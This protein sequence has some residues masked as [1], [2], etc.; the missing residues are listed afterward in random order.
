MALVFTNRAA[1]AN[2][3][4]G[5]IFDTAAFTPSASAGII[6]ALWNS[7]ASTPDLGTLSTPSWLSGAW[8]PAEIDLVSAGAVRRMTVYSGFTV[9]S[10]GSDFVRATFGA[11]QT[12]CVTIVD[13]VTGQDLTDFVLQ[14][15]VENEAAG[16][17]AA[18]TL[19]NALAGAD[20][21]IWSACG[22]NGNEA[23]APAGGE[24]ELADVGTTAPIT[25]LQTQ[26]Q[27]NDLTSSVSWTNSFGQVTIGALEV[28]AAGAAVASS[29]PEP[30][31][32]PS[33]TQVA[34]VERS[35]RW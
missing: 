12:G 7:K 28:K 10:P 11:T 19:A 15:V 23:Q 24:T 29:G 5:T 20:S 17:S 13:D 6:V 2:N 21:A 34:A 9:A 33:L 26:F 16:T 4:D 3:V 1:I 27:I 30:I 22:I 18:I 8:S 32:V 25:H 14:P 35:R 31:T